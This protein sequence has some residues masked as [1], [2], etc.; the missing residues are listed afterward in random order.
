MKCDVPIYR[1]PYKLKKQIFS[2]T[3]EHNCAL[4]LKDKKN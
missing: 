3:V 4:V 2:V 1:S